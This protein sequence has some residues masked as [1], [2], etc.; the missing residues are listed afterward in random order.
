MVRKNEVQPAAVDVEG[1][2]EK[3]HRHGRAFDV[4]ARAPAPPG[5]IPRRLPRLLCLPQGEIERVP[6]VFP[7]HHALAG[8][9]LLHIPVAQLGVPR[10]LGHGE[11]D[12]PTGDIGH[13]GIEQL[14]H[15]G[16][17]FRHVVRHPGGDVRLEH[18]EAAHVLVKGLDEAVCQRLG[19][20]SRSLRRLNNAV[21]DVR[22][23]A[24]VGDAVAAV[25]QITHH[26]VEGGEGPGI[27]Q[28]HVAV[29]GGATHIQPHFS[30][31]QGVQRLLALRQGVEK[32]QACG[33]LG[34]R[35]QR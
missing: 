7:R 27:A 30:G 14:L 21:V 24:H 5:G 28:V 31:P 35:G 10:P 8:A 17:N 16:Q 6:L 18:S 4:P 20:L 13:T 26:D 29:D 32:L 33:G 25:A 34:R 9:E 3:L 19:V 15:E 12:V 11:K 23:I 1:L 2:S 22:D